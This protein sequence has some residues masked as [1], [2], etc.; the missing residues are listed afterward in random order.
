[1]KKWVI[2]VLAVVAVIVILAAAV[3]IKTLTFASKQVKVQEKVTCSLDREQISQRL[4]GAIRYKT[5][6]NEDVSKVDFEPFKKLQEYL[7]VSFPLVESRLEKKVINN[8]ALLYTWKGSGTTG[9]PILLLAHMDVVPASEEGWKHAPFAGDVAENSIWGRGTL[10]DKCTVM[11][12]LEAIEYLLKANYTPSRTIYLAYGFDEEITGKEGAGQIAT[13][14]RGQGLDFEYMLDEGDLIISG[15]VP[16]ISAPVALVGTAEKGYLSLELS[17]ESESG[18]SSMP[19]RETAVGILAKAITR[20]E[21]N[22]FPSRMSGPTGDMFEYLGPEMRFPYNMIFANMWLLKPVVEDQLA[23]SPSTD[24]T[25]RTTIAPTMLK[26]SERDNILPARAS[27]VVNFR[28]MPGDSIDSVIKRVSTVI[29]DPRV[30]IKIYN[31]EGRTEPSAITSTGSWGYQTLSKTVRQVF[32]DALVGP[33]LVN[34]YSDSSQYAGLS[35]TV[36][37][38]LPQKLDIKEIGMLHGVNE[39][40]TVDNYIEMITFY[41]QLIRNSNS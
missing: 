10:D 36:L 16:G 30:V 1:M 13:Y 23:S 11:A 15:A 38:F 39:R 8:Y 3:A 21:Q 22:P 33:A 4:A 37:R 28:L 31:P 27:A 24:A 26:A 25:L 34:S 19:P 12:Q 32:P 5:V 9:K 40:I 6:F 20:L 41:I 18:H 29:N 17:V 7:A 35:D 14:L 2:A